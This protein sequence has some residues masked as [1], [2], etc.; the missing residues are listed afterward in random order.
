M[1]NKE[2]TAVD[3]EKSFGT[4]IDFEEVEQRLEL[5]VWVFDTHDGETS[6]CGCTC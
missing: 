2:L 5:G 1:K 3:L 4:A 6:C